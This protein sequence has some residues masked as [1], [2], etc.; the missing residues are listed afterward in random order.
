MAGKKV[1]S[2][3]GACPLQLLTRKEV[4]KRASRMPVADKNRIFK[5]PLQEFHK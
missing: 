5:R 1:I 2:R 4:A 3:A